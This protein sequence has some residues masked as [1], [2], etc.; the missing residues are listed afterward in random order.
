MTTLTLHSYLHKI[1]Q[2]LDDNRF[3][4]AASHCRHILEQYPRHIDTYR[5]LAKVLLEQHQYE[6]AADLFQRVLSA[7]PNDLVA[8]VGL[9]DIYKQDSLLDQSLWH[10]ERAFELEPYNRVIQ[11][12][13]RHLYAQRND[14]TLERIPLNQGALAHIYVREELYG[15]AVSE[16]RQALS[17][18]GERVD[19]EV[20]LAEALWR[21]EQRVDA[22]ELCQ[23]I[24][25]QLPNCIVANAIL[26]DIWLQ[27]GRAGEAQPYLQRV[28]AL[29]QMDNRR[30][31]LETA[32]GHAFG[33]E[34]APSLPDEV[35]IEVL[36]MARVG[37]APAAPTADWISEV[38]FP[39]EAAEQ[40]A[41]EEADAAY[42]QPEVVYDWLVGLDEEAEPASRDSNFEDVADLFGE[43]DPLSL[44]EGPDGDLELADSTAYMPS[45][46]SDET[47]DD[48][49]HRS[50]PT[51]E[52]VPDWL[53]E[54][55]ADSEAT[56]DEQ[57]AEPAEIPSSMQHQE[58]PDWLADVSN[59][60]DFEPME[61]DRM[62]ASEWFGE[63]E[64]E[65]AEGEVESMASMGEDDD[66]LAELA[67]DRGE[68]EEASTE[69][70][71]AVAG[72]DSDWL[73][74][75]F[76][77]S[78]FQEETATD[79]G[80]PGTGD[81][82]LAA[83]T[84]DTDELPAQ[85]GAEDGE[86]LPA[87]S[88]DWLV[89]DT[90]DTEYGDEVTDWLLG[91]DLIEQDKLE[92]VMAGIPVDDSDKKDSS[93]EDVPEPEDEVSVEP[94]DAMA[95]LDALTAAQDE[96][97]PSVMEQ[98]AGEGLPDWL[99]DLSSPADRMDDVAEAATTAPDYDDDIPDWLRVSSLD[100][101]L[102]SAE[103]EEAAPAGEDELSYLDRIAAGE[104]APIDEPPTQVSMA[105]PDMTADEDE[106][107][108]TG[109]LSELASEGSQ[110]EDAEGLDWLDQIAGGAPVDQI[111]TLA[112]SDE[113]GDEE[114]ALD[115]LSELAA[116]PDET[117]VNL[118][119]TQMEAGSTQG[120][121]AE[122]E[123]T[124]VE[125]PEDLDD[126]M[127]WLEELAAQQGA[128]VE[129]LPTVANVLERD[130]VA[131]TADEE[132]VRAESQAM[133]EAEAEPE[134]TD[135]EMVE[136]FA[137]VPEQP[138]VA[139]LDDAMAWL[140][141][142]AAEQGIPLEELPGLREI[143]EEVG[144]ETEL[145]VMAV[146]VEEEL[147][148]EEADVLPP[149]PDDLL[150]E[151]EI[152]LDEAMAWLEE[153]V[154]QQ[155]A[156]VETW[157]EEADLEEAELAAAADAITAHDELEEALDWL[158]QVALEEG[159][160]AEV[161]NVAVEVTDDELE[162]AL[163]WLE[164]VAVAEAEPVLSPRR[165][166]DVEAVVAEAEP[167]ISD[168]SD[169]EEAVTVIAAKPDEPDDDL[170]DIPDDPEAALAWLEQVAAESEAE[171][172]AESETGTDRDVLADEEE[173]DEA[174]ARAELPEA[175][176]ADSGQGDE[177]AAE[178]DLDFLADMPD[179]PDEAMAWLERLAARQGAPLEELPSISA[180][181]AE[182]I[183]MLAETMPG[184]LEAEAAIEE[185]ELI[186]EAEVTEDIDVMGWLEAE[187]EATVI[188]SEEPVRVPATG[189]LLE[190][191]PEQPAVDQEPSFD[192]EDE[193]LVL[194][195]PEPVTSALALDEIQ[196]ARARQALADADYDEAMHTYQSLVIKGE[197]LIT[198]IGDLETAVSQHP[199]RP[200]LRRV[201]GDAYMR[202]GQ[203]Q[204]AL[205][206]YRQTLDHL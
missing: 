188:S 34:G 143:E 152:D 102:F 91:S 140:E 20:V 175:F 153:L 32:V 173:A 142:L 29:T 54:R 23:H 65:A 82:W 180:E 26:A 99:A 154:G 15:Q 134:A 93:L 62:L 179:D 22:A 176:V 114:P 122:E 200:L 158:E 119:K 104:G 108:V 125:V 160:L 27:T 92:E 128:P 7:D 113:L 74:A 37:A 124:V 55:T 183:A 199:Q 98:L 42:G 67:I 135:E 85:A 167:E 115:W 189:P 60:D 147:V 33:L 3:S 172:E 138:P 14:L 145:E 146:E 25:D 87:E 120:G 39:S 66:W 43:S 2:L 18:N 177:E 30:L 178:P 132:D 72:E 144:A 61:V 103:E 9:A 187:E 127:A 206:T 205:E 118:E 174:P 1:D 6:N 52:E 196:L 181:E 117:L 126:A 193:S 190:A 162:E 48:V 58:M 63:A 73:T 156:P 78:L 149:E 35:K 11:D 13:L 95:W 45:W 70:E 109:W 90:A 5:V 36:E 148:V 51:P 129:E 203:L 169:E 12:E 185:V 96:P 76:E 56:F 88:V 201:L 157:A 155:D 182:D 28:Q 16:L 123:D 81:D 164:Q 38:T 168:V 111:P 97:E 121:E 69:A 44:D 137:D 106:T 31:D 86:P 71:P 64:D 59:A 49:D 161:E 100:D 198:L 46:L 41:V 83:L 110:D 131:D 17:Q 141:E 197:G 101:E 171:L 159:A 80:D 194:A 186:D 139:D 79:D 204:K 21:D 184:W 166:E 89:E 112:W 195:E 107:E 116:A 4:E 24:L 19:L 165:T 75:E 84:R 133:A 68:P 105:S 130:M 163:D 94:D 77:G 57:A 192:D 136:P 202:N 191:S 53:S 47:A 151:A 150:A 40:S 10:L 8:H 50:L 170:F